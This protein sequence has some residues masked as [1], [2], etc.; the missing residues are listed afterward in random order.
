MPVRNRTISQDLSPGATE[1][2]GADGGRGTPLDMAWTLRILRRNLLL[3]AGIVAAMLALAVGYLSI[4]TPL[5]TATGEL[6]FDLREPKIVSA[7]PILQSFGADQYVIDSQVEVVRSLSVARRVINQL[8]LRQKP[9]TASV[10]LWKRWLD[11][12]PAATKPAADDIPQSDYNAFLR[13]LTVQ[14]KGVSF[15]ILVSYSHPD[16]VKAAAITNAVMDAYTSEQRRV[17]VETIAAANNWLQNRV[18]ELRLKVI[19][20]E[21]R[22]QQFKTEDAAID[23]KVMNTIYA[24]FLTRLKETQQQ[25][26]LQ[27]SDARIVSTAVAPTQPSSPKKVLTMALALALGLSI[28]SLVA[29]ARGMVDPVLYDAEDVARITDVPIIVQLPHRSAQELRRLAEAH[30]QAPQSEDVCDEDGEEPSRRPARPQDSAYGQAMFTLRQALIDTTQMDAHRLVAIVSPRA[31]EGKTTTAL[32]LAREAAASGSRT[33]IVDADLRSGAASAVMAPDA[34]ERSLVDYVFGAATL[35]ETLV[36]D[37]LSSAMIC[38]A[39]DAEHAVERPTDVIAGR[40]FFKAARDM[41]KDF[42][43]VIFDTPGFLDYPDS[44]ALLRAVDRVVA[45]VDLGQTTRQDLRAL[46]AIASALPQGLA[47]LALNTSGNRRTTETDPASL[48]IASK[49]PWLFE[50]AQRKNREG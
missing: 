34:R 6:I 42:D 1:G 27:A 39:P 37:A 18:D 17:K 20:A 15:V 25:E 11:F 43:L 49:L 9:S 29:V 47:G 7:N 24:T 36:K 46:I 19:E 13:R 4:A 8:D 28:G 35:K 45:V 30:V 10:P 21:R 3:I 38:P 2:S 23:A 31:G 32:N 14:R 41:R 26:A 50:R 16:P 5:Y 48:Q 33:L 44:R 22:V 40:G 12:G